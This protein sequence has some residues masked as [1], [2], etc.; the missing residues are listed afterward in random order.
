M[1]KF[2]RLALLIILGVILLP[3]SANAA[4]PGPQT[5]PRFG[6]YVRDHVGLTGSV[7]ARAAGARWIHLLLLW[8]Q[9]EKSPGEYDWSVSD[10]Y[11]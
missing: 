8:N 7:Q 9:I 3:R 2:L 4:P 11:L 10:S 5:A 6:V 1:H